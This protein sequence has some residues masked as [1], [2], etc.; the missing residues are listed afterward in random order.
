MIFKI[1]RNDNPG[2]Y[3]YTW[4]DLMEECANF[5]STEDFREVC[6]KNAKIKIYFNELSHYGLECSNRNNNEKCT[7]Y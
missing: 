1:L 3:I 6:A 2:G 7:C 4:E 5:K